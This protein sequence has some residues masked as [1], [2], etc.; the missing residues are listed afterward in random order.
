MSNKYQNMP[1]ITKEELKEGMKLCTE[2]ILKILP[3]F[4]H[5]FQTPNS[6]DLFYGKAENKG[7]TT[8]FWTGEIWLAYEFSKDE[9]LKEAALIQCD[10]FAHRIEN[11]IATSDHDLGFLYSLS[12][13][14][15]YKLTGNEK[16]KNSAL[17]AAEELMKL[18]VPVGGFITTWNEILEGGYYRVIIDCLMNI[19][20]LYWA[21]EVTGEGKYREAAKNHFLTT[22]R[23]ALAED[24]QTHQVM[25][26]EAATGKL[27][28][29]TTK[30]GYSDGSAWSRGQAWGIYGSALTYK[31]TQMEECVDMF[32]KTADYFIKHLPKDM[33][34]YFDLTF[35]EGDE[36]PRDSSAAAIAVC[37]M[38]EMAKYLPQEEAE[39]YIRYAKQIMK[40]LYDNYQVKDFNKSNGILMHGTY[41][42]KTPHNGMTRDI[43]VDE[44][45][46]FGDYFYM[47]ALSRLL[48]DW[49][50]YW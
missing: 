22:Y 32:R 8:S 39:K 13:V 31:Y 48:T 6:T 14:A 5:D 43:G 21:S 16:A 12:C 38:L 35:T 47:E 37:G 45:C 30:Q 49:E 10:N 40:S 9:K 46:S 50:I 7:W 42:C 33:V 26:F 44:C 27:R 36:W 24:G 4:T 25:W 34:A 20:L 19:P 11:K 1:L 41:S 29:C 2:Q 28:R 23:S 3:E 18:Y 15:A 17:A